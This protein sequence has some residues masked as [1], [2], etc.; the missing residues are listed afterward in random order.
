VYRTR[1]IQTLQLDPR[2]LYRFDV[3][4]LGADSLGD[5]GYELSALMDEAFRNRLD[6]Q[7]AQAER[8]AANRSVRVARSSYYPSLSISGGY[9]TDWT[10]RARPIPDPETGEMIDPSFSRQLDNN[11]SGSVSLSLSIPIFDQFQRNAQVQ[12]AQV[13]EQNAQYALED[14]RQQIAL[15]VR[16]AYLDYRN[17]V[18]QLEAANKRLRAARQA[19]DAARERYNLGSAS[20]VELQ[21]ATRDFVDAASQQ[22]RARYNLVFFRKQIDYHVGRLN[23]SA[24]L[25]T[26]RGDQ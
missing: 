10:S 14:Q 18:Q 4:E 26:S 11:R 6:L 2:G 22:V 1:I 24:S 19:R 25:F 7:A 13:Q 3:P 20:I 5:E 21:T 17:A 23:P 9:G 16:Q 8:R 15:Q 12:R